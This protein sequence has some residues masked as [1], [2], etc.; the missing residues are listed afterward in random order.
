M[1]SFVLLADV[2]NTNTK[3]GIS[4]GERILSTFALPTDPRAT[5]DSLGLAYLQL[6][7]CAGVDPVAARAWV[8]SSVVP[9]LDQLVRKAGER[10]GRCPVLFV[11]RDLPLPLENRYA[12]P[13]EVG[14]DRLVTAFA[15]RGLTRTRSLIVIDFGTATTFDCVQDNAYL[16]G[17]ICP[18]LLSSMRSLGTQTAKLPQISLESADRELHIGRSTADSLRQGLLFGF[19]AMVDGLCERLGAILEGETT[20]L[21]TGGLANV[22]RPLCRCLDAVHPDLL[23]SGLAKAYLQSSNQ[24]DLR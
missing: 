14:A 9:P 21:A 13:E 15:G 5:E 7:A 23:L 3:Y 1:N 2:G 24:G 11:P 17:L 8:V 16:G 6:C 18:G 20:V 12:K 4:D 22:L 19:S 10:F